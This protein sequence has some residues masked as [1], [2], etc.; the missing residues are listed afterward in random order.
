[1]ALQPKMSDPL[2]NSTPLS[3]LPSSLHTRHVFSFTSPFSPACC[4]A[5]YVLPLLSQQAQ[6]SA[7]EARSGGF[8]LRS[9]WSRPATLCSSAAPRRPPSSTPSSATSTSSPSPHSTHL[10]KKHSD[11]HPFDD[12]TSVE[13]LCSK[14]DASLFFLASDSKKRPHNLTFGRLFDYQVLDM[15]EYGV[16][17]AGS[18]K[19]ISGVRGLATRRRC[20]MAVSRWCCSRA[21]GGRGAATTGRVQRS[22][23]LD[24]CKGET[25]DRINLSAVDRVI[26]LTAIWNPAHCTSD[27]TRSHS[28][29]PPRACPTSRSMRSALT[30]HSHCDAATSPPQT[31]SSSPCSSPS[32]PTAPRRAQEPQPQRSGR[33]DGQSAHA[34]TRLEQCRYCQAERTEAKQTGRERRVRLQ[35]EPGQVRR[36]LVT[37]RGESVLSG[38]KRR[39][40]VSGA[41]GYGPNRN[42]ES[43]AV[44]CKS[45][46]APSDRVNGGNRYRGV[47]SIGGGVQ[48]HLYING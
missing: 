24:W 22:M 1:M 16:E 45:R 28:N 48:L 43:A 17:A 36:W 7:L 23:W 5:V 25:L 27:T 38:E 46:V 13:F 15:V 4:V 14:A 3:S 20:G 35:T 19:G 34:A 26:V 11:C 41:G 42:A 39:K 12:P 47:C 30:S 21:S 2:N 37:R 10:H 31:S 44:A 29:P 33:R 18:Y 6:D 40:G 32:A 8:A 9:L